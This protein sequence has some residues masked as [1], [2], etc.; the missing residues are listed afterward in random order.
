MLMMMWLMMMSMLI[1]GMFVPMIMAV[2]MDCDV[3]RDFKNCEHAVL[4][5]RMV[6]TVIIGTE[7]VLSEN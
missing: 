1:A 7:S 4:L 3:Y 5:V 6:L 2:V